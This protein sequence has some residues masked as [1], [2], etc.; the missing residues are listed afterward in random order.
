VSIPRIPGFSTSDRP[1][2]LADLWTRPAGD[3]PDELWPDAT[4]REIIAAPTGWVRIEEYYFEDHHHGGRGAVLVEAADVPQALSH[5][6]WI[7]RDLGG[8]G[9]WTD[10]D[11]DQAFEDGLTAR[12]HGVETK[13]LVQVRR[14]HG[15]HDPVVEISHPFVWYWDAIQSADGWYCLDGAG[16]DQPLIRYGVSEKTWTVD[17]RALP[18]RRYLADS[19][20]VLVVQVDHV[21]K[22]SA[23]ICSTVESEFES[24]WARFGWWSRPERLT[25]DRPHFSRLLGKY[26]VDGSMDAAIPRWEYSKTDIDFPEFVYGI[27][28]D[29]GRHLT[30]TCDPD[31]LGTYFDQDDSLLHYLTPVYFD[32]RVLSKYTD[33]PLRYEV[34]PGDLSCLDIWSVAFSFNTAGLVEVYLGD[35]GRDIPSQEWGHWQSYNVPPEGQMSEARFR[36]DFL[37][38]WASSDDPIGDVRS[39]RQQINS[40]AQSYLG[41]P[42]WRELEEPD[43]TEFERLHSVATEPALKLAILSLCKAF[44]EAIDQGVLAGFTGSTESEDRT[45]ALMEALC[46]TLEGDRTIVEPLRALQRLRSKGGI[47]HMVSSQRA[48]ALRR[49]GIDNMDPAP[50][51][52]TILRRL[53]GFLRELNRL[54]AQAFA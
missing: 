6:A 22:E 11:G 31:E 40:V 14:Q 17:V 54:L 8:V 29:S 48:S 43:R 32:P 4:L 10:R 46:E 45:L 9:V 26:V 20:Q 39:L 28:P 38:Q 12:D 42:I 19:G 5:D 52:Q 34:R 21:C 13:F 3:Y 25:G 7:G 51:F 44:I 50:A 23:E 15:L 53:L 33:E 47:A 37:A 41:G 49:L 18:L 2:S 27:D 36:R 1:E 16:Q 35:I 30:H 24:D